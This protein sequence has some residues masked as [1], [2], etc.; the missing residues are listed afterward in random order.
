M[1]GARDGVESLRTEHLD[2]DWFIPCEFI[3]HR[4]AEPATWILFPACCSVNGKVYAFACDA[5][6]SRKTSLSSGIWCLECNTR[7]TPASRAWR[8]V[9][10]IGR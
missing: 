3:G 4:G 6:K 9:E 7:Y 2:E 8:R 5:C 10:L 1:N